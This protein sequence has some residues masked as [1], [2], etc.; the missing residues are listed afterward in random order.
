MPDTPH[1]TDAVSDFLE[2]AELFRFSEDAR[3]EMNSFF[4][5]GQEV[6][7]SDLVLEQ[8]RALAYLNAAE[9]SLL[10]EFINP[11]ELSAPALYGGIV[12]VSGNDI[13]LALLKGDCSLIIWTHAPTQDR[14]RLLSVSDLTVF[15]GDA[16]KMA[17][18]TQIEALDQSLRL[19]EIGEYVT[20]LNR[21]YTEHRWLPDVDIGRSGIIQLQGLLWF[22]K[23]AVVQEATEEGFRAALA[24]AR[25][26]VTSVAWG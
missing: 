18:I 21:V 20:A 16:S 2:A 23:A 5:V 8:S 4:E 24:L 6:P 10:P 7:V 14:V 17:R 11:K 19:P 26:F 1:Y 9:Y 15:G 3:D 13:R 12:T 25:S 22:L